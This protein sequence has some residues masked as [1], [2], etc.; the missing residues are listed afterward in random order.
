[1][2]EMTTEDQKG[3]PGVLNV[4]TMWAGRFGI[5]LLFLL[6]PTLSVFQP[7]LKRRLRHLRRQLTKRASTPFGRC[8]LKQDG[9]VTMKL[10][11]RMMAACAIIALLGPV[12]AAAQEGSSG[13]IEEVHGTV[14]L[15]RSNARQERLDPK[16]DAARRLYP[17]DR[18]RCTRGSLLR[19]NLGGE[20]RT[21]Q[22]TAWFTIPQPDS[23]VPTQFRQMLDDYAYRGSRDRALP[24]QVYSPTNYG[25]VL[26]EDFVIRWA[27]YTLGCT[28]SLSVQDVATARVW[29]KDN[30]DSGA[31][32]INDASARRALAG[33][34]AKVGTGPLKLVVNDSCGSTTTVSFSVLSAE[35][36]RLLKT[37]L[38]FWETQTG[39]FVRRIGRASI[40]N[41]FRLFPQAAEE[42]EAA[43][44]EAPDS[45]YLL[46]RTITAH[47][48][49]GNFARADELKKR[50]PSG[51]KIE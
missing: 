47:R 19:I 38:A 33:Y 42:Y 30:V 27:P 39:A 9:G 37:D 28:F 18:V 36:E 4:A 32:S 25:A 49:S 21:I 8:T 26:I 50:L 10:R 3:V 13:I 45:W 7:S 40:Y 17:G 20:P 24:I 46:T 12:A 48:T 6:T 35:E 31:G 1:M 2:N 14:F 51:L 5:N 16:Q 44:S 43:L 34:R 11:P 41:R 23:S 15:K 22:T 29:R